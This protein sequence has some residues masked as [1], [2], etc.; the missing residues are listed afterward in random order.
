MSLVLK[1]AR[2][3]DPASGRD[4]IADVWIER[5]RIAGIDRTIDREDARRVDLTGRVVVPGLVD[6]HVHLREPGRE[7]EETIESGT[8]AAVRGGFT[9]VVCMPNTEPALDTDASIQYVLERARTAG[10]CRVLPVGAITRGREGKALSEIGS[11]V[12]AGAVAISDD[13][14]S[15]EDADLM[16]RA[17]E[18][19]R[20]LGI[21]VTAHCEDH[22]LSGQGV[23][24]EGTLSTLL[25]LKG[26][27]PQAEA[28]R[29][30]RDIMLAELTRSH[31]HVQHVSTAR[32][33][34]LV[35][36][37]KARGLAVTAEATP[38]HLVLTEEAVRAYDS[39]AKVNPPLRGEEDRAALREGLVSGAIDAVATDHAP[40][41]HEE[42][43][44]EF[45]GAAFGMVGLETAVGLVLTELVRPG[46]LDLRDAVRLLTTGPAGVLGRNLGRLEPGR[47]ADVTILDLDEVWTVDPTAFASH[48]RNTPFA[49]RELTGRPVGT[50][51]GGRFVMWNGK[52]RRF[53]E[54]VP[55]ATSGAAR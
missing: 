43:E 53:G 42:K 26:S 40:H 41:S 50:L 4:E 25:G 49:G 55:C 5:G 14:A 9:T 23:M 16:R 12:E 48:S 27:P 17:L 6:L 24:N 11:L 19:A 31:L 29:V 2:V 3:L 1:N 22:T 36:E 34:A 45:D 44:I 52:V 38:H 39:M 8:R 21:P 35:A 46:V 51:V 7:D 33:V 47:P 15:V 18:Y 28:A 13:G 37:A 30:A 20:M 54:E 10:F 32:S